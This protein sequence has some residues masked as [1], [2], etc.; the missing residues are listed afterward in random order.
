MSFDRTKLT[1]RSLLGAAAGAG[2]LAVLAGASGEGPASQEPTPEELARRY[3]HGPL[4][5]GARGHVDPAA[6][7]FDPHEMLRDFD[8]GHDDRLPERPRAARVGR[9]SPRTR[10]S[11]SRPAS[12]SRPG[13]TTAACP[14]PTLRATRG[15]PAADHASSTAPRT[16]TRSTSTASTRPTWTAS[17]ASGRG[18]ADRAGRAASS[19]SSTPLPVRPAPLPLPRVPAGRA[20]SPRASTARSSSTRQGRP[21]GAD[22]L[23]MVMNGFD[24][25]FDRANEVYAVNTVASPTWT[26]RSRSRATSSCGST[27]STSS[28]STRSTRSTCTATSSTTTRPARR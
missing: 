6:N 10:R 27:S 19:T 24:T 21:R 8:C 25:N 22:E 15:R 2:A 7:G 16:R 28:S 11:R 18:R 14:G 12:R 26:T 3:P 23:V 20:T 1:R 17:P 9:W 5:S 13:P 4:H